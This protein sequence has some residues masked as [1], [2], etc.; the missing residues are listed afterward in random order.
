MAVVEPLLRTKIQIFSYTNQ[1]LMCPC[2]NPFPVIVKNMINIIWVASPPS[3]SRA[4]LWS[5]STRWTRWTLCYSGQVLPMRSISNRIRLISP[6]NWTFKIG[7]TKIRFDHFI[8]IYLILNQVLVT[9]YF[10]NKLNLFFL[11]DST[12][13]S[14]HFRV[15]FFRWRQYQ[16]SY[17]P[18]W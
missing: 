15:S 17:P 6:K 7:A 14:L 11:S 8:N 9:L 1:V 3:K 2:D 10:W 5:P 16:R 13:Q 12:D 4:L 18:A